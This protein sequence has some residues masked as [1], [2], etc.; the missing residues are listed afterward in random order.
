M[1]QFQCTPDEVGGSGVKFLH[2][3]LTLDVLMPVFNG[4]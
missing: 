3:Q 1:Y 4:K 2:Y